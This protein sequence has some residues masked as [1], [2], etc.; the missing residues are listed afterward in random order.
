MCA[1]LHLHLKGLL[2]VR[3]RGLRSPQIAGSQCLG[4]AVEAANQIVPARRLRERGP[5]LEILLQSRKRGSRRGKIA[6][7]KGLRR[8]LEVNWRAAGCVLRVVRRVVVINRID[9]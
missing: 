6:R 2:Q 4:D 8:V 7:L 5:G 3:I 1:G 9:A